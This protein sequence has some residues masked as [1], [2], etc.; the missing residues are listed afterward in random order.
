MDI[1]N[2]NIFAKVR[3]YAESVPVD[4]DALCNDMGICVSYEEMNDDTSG[5]IEKSGDNWCDYTIRINQSDPETRQ[6]FTI[7]HELGQFLFHGSKIGDGITDNRLYMHYEN[8]NNN[9]VNLQMET[10]A[11]TFAANLL[12]PKS[13]IKNEIE[14]GLSVE[15][16]AKVMIVSIKSLQVRVE[17]MQREKLIVTPG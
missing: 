13:H 2:K 1:V 5:S 9:A 11:N 15:Q 10:E 7:A 6:R 4:L 12:M 3:S 14:R 17:A 16:L 8:R